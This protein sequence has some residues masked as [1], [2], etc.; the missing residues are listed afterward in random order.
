[1][2]AAALALCVTVWVALRR[3]AAPQQ[4]HQPTAAA[5]SSSSFVAYERDCDFPI[6]NLPYGVFVRRGDATATRRVGVAIG[7]SVSADTAQHLTVKS[8]KAT[9]FS[10]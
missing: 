7:E 8:P 9:L 10:T 5:M 6:E 4:A 2:A 3:E 1:V